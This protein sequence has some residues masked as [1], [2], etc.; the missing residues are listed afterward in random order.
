[1]GESYCT[2]GQYVSRSDELVVA[3]ECAAGRGAVNRGAIHRTFCGESLA[4]VGRGRQRPCLA[5]GQGPGRGLGA[6]PVGA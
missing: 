4:A 3:A 2:K 6:A 5:C 1:M